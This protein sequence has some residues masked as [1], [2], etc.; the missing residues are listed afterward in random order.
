MNGYRDELTPFIRTLF[1]NT[2]KT[3]PSLERGVMTGITCLS[4]E[5]ILTELNHLVTV[6]ATSE[7]YA[8]AFGFTEQEVFAALERQ[9][10]TENDKKDVKSCYG[11]FTFGGTELYNPW[12]VICFLSTGKFDT[13]WANTSENGLVGTLLRKGGPDIKHEFENL[14]KGGNVTVPV[15]EQMF[16]NPLDT[17]PE[18]VWSFLLASGYLKVVQ[19]YQ[20]SRPF[21]RTPNPFIP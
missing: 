4:K 21:V 12:A 5:S 16:Y 2:F 20:K 8:A 3:N 7:Q 11:G 19:S 9:G 18:A 15:D 10:F 17:N 13:Y 14:L 6:T 1:S